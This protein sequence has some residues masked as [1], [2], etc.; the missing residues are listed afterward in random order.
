[1]VWNMVYLHQI[2]STGARASLSLG[3]IVKVGRKEPPL[4]EVVLV[5]QELKE[6]VD[7]RRHSLL[8]LHG[9]QPVVGLMKVV[10]TLSKMPIPT[11]R[12]AYTCEFWRF[13][14]A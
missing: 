11:R 3:E 2:L 1:M 10:G 7:S 13:D 6:L 4:G 5:F 9:L 8:P 14:L 12:S